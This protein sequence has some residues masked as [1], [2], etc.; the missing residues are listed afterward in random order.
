MHNI[1][2]MMY[3]GAVPWHGLGKK[4]DHVATAAEA[5]QAA[6]LDWKVSKVPMFLKDGRQ[7]PSRWA[8]LRED[9]QD[10]LGTV[11]DVYTVLQNREA[12]SFFDAIV[13]LKEAIYHTAGALGLGEKV[14]I[15]A[16][17][18][19]QVKVTSE[20][21]TDK[22]LLLTNTHDGSGAVSVMFTPIRVVCQNTLNIAMAAGSR[23]QKV[24]HTASMGLQVRNIQEGLGI[25][26]QQFQAFEEAARALTGVQVNGEKWKAYLKDLGII[27]AEATSGTIGQSRMSTRAQ[28]IIEEV[29]SFFEHGKGQQLPGVRGTAWAA[30]NAIG[31]YVDYARTA[32]GGAS[33]LQA[34]ASS[35]L[36]GSGQALKQKAWD[37]AVALIA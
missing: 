23:K 13:G 31:E 2:S 35:L 21:V 5:I 14:W 9:S 26:N 4:L 1:N 30:F 22:F 24:R 10:I 8:N 27:P 19:G 20:D 18:P 11:G 7:V 3:T 37:G 34:R 16:K 25:V 6:G 36:F 32:R 12:F 33:P 29:T 15:L 17:L 28:N